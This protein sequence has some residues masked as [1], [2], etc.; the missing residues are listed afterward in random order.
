MSWLP[1][2]RRSGQT[3]EFVGSADRDGAWRCCADAGQGHICGRGD[4][5][6]TGYSRRAARHQR[7]AAGGRGDCD[8]ARRSGR[9]SRAR[10]D[11]PH[12][13]RRHAGCRNRGGADGTWRVMLPQMAEGPHT[14][15]VR[16][17]SPDG[18]EANPSAPVIVVVRPALITT[19]VPA[20]SG[21][22]ASAARP[23]VSSPAAGGRSNP[24]SRCCRARPLRAA[25]CASMP[26]TC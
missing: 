17:V 22:A 16:V 12:L 5:S 15:V 26:A 11:D 23:S 13:R 19:P 4:A 25:R 6:G 10:L 7:A 14:F 24:A 8:I 21:A 9:Q 20:A 3:G 2:L 1:R 18:S